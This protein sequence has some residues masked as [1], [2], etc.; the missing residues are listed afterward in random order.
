MPAI[1]NAPDTTSTIEILQERYMS[2]VF[3]QVPSYSILR[4]KIKFDQSAQPGEAF[5]FAMLVRYPHGHTWQGGSRYGQVVTMNS[6]VNG[7]VIQG[8]VTP[9]TQTLREQLSWDLMAASATS[10]QAFARGA[11]LLVAATV[12]SADWALELALM[13]GGGD[14]GAITSNTPTTGLLSDV[15]ISLASWAPAN[16]SAFEGGYVDCYNAAL[17]VK[18]NTDGPIL[19]NA[20]DV[21]ARTCEM[22]FASAGDQAACGATD[23][24]VPLGAAT[25]WQ[26]G[27]MR[28]L[29]LSIAGSSLYGITTADYGLTR[30]STYAAGGAAL[31]FTKLGE[32]AAA[33]VAKGGMGNYLAL[34]SPWAWTDINNQQAANRRYTEAGKGEFVNGGDELTYYGP[35]G[36]TIT[37][38]QH[39][40]MK[41]GEAIMIDPK[42]WVRSGPSEP[43]FNIPGQGQLA[44]QSM[45][46]PLP[47]QTGTQFV[48]YWS[49]APAC[50][51]LAKQIKITGIVNTSLA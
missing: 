31:S 3:D 25:N 46:T 48:R 17:T 13:H 5:N 10:S 27:V 35:N 2:G 11:D 42:D 16:W 18:Q 37:V 23:V 4:D 33:G 1:P 15:V 49:Q 39:A 21:S 19:I 29:D 40:M 24:F 36:G 26:P 6:A 20:I 38:V 9:C 34:V 41:A 22:E 30:A 12:D 14:I 32:A 8:R 44:I 28:A 45:L 51:R 47:D 50:V 43:T 7:R